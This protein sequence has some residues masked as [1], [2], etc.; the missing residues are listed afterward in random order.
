M[1]HLLGE[2]VLNE[3]RPD[4]RVLD[5]GT[6]CGVNAAA[7]RPRP[8]LRPGPAVLHAAEDGANTFTLLAF[9][10]H[11]SVASLAR[12]A[13]VSP[14]ALARWREGRDPASRRR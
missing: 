7:R 4:D 13:R 6:G 5:M 12:Y 3:V 9:S 11:T 10:G 14:D 2:A 1:S 8:R